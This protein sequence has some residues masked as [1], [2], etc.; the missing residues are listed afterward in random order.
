MTNTPSNTIE[1]LMDRIKYETDIEELRNHALVLLLAFDDPDK[2]EDIYQ[3]ELSQDG[4]YDHYEGEDQEYDP[5]GG[6]F[7]TEEER[8]GWD[9]AIGFSVDI[10]KRKVQ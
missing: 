5:T 8:E 1:W 10:A 2:I 4:Y 3:A 7:A 9:L 6:R